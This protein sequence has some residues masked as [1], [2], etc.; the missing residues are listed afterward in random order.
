[1]VQDAGVRVFRWWKHPAVLVAFLPVHLKVYDAGRYA[2]S[3]T[4][5]LSKSPTTFEL[6]DDGLVIAC[7]V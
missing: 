2:V 1:M 7:E 4:G 3:A 6:Q 5:L